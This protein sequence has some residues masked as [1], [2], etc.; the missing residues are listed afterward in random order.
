MTNTCIGFTNQ[1]FFVVLCFYISLACFGGLGFGLKY[2][3]NEYYAHVPLWDYFLPVTL[4]QW[5]YGVY[6]IDAVFLVC[7]L[8][9][10]PPVGFLCS[11]FLIFQIALVATGKTPFELLKNLHQKNSHSISRNI[12]SVFGRFWLMNFLLPFHLLYKQTDDPT[13]WPNMKIYYKG[14][15][16][17]EKIT[18]NVTV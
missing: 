12:E 11:A 1:R 7:H 3:Y 13:N 16:N 8:Y 4:Y 17:G 14:H 9:L 5:Y 2:L 6:P 18:K 15:L 10:L